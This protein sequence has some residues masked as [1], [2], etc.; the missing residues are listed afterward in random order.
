LI[1]D[2]QVVELDENDEILV[3]VEV[4]DD[5]VDE[6]EDEVEVELLSVD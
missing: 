1:L 3:Q 2:E 5:E 6:D 4:E